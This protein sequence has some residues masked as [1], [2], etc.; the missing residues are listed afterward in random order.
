[1]KLKRLLA[2]VAAT[3]MAVSTMAVSASAIEQTTAPDGT[4]YKAEMW[5]ADS[6]W[7][8]NTMDAV[9][10]PAA[11]YYDAY[12]TGDG[13]YTVSNVKTEGIDTYSV[14]PFGYVVFCVD[15]EGLA[16]A[17]GC[18]ANSEGYKDTCVD[19]ATKMQFA[20][21]AGLTIKDVKILQ[22]GEV[23]CEV[24]N[25]KLI[26]GDIEANGKI[27]LELYNEYG[28]SKTIGDPAVQALAG[29]AE[30][31]ESIQVQFTIEGVDKLFSAGAPET[32]TKPDTDTTPDGDTAP[33]DEKPTD[34]GL[35]GVA[36]A[37][38]AVAGASVVATKKRK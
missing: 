23:V 14:D 24:A 5:F 19:T 1:M 25:D 32:P 11:D 20:K 37:G 15:I 36:L 2:G 12:I 35:A 18:G 31:F 3:A 4:S 6:S 7:L 13:T 27:R 34:T 38:L 16:D 29:E 28:D 26:Y 17:M 22:D 9:A 8:W 10:N 30:W 21:D 33:D